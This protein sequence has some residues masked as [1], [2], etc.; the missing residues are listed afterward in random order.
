MPY[1]DAIPLSSKPRYGD[2]VSWSGSYGACMGQGYGHI[3]I[4]ISGDPGSGTIKVL[5][6]NPGQARIDNLPVAGVM[7]WMRPKK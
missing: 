5:T 3:A 7:G 2:I 4:Y 1:C 6:Q